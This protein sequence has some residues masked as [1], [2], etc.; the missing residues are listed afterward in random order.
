MAEKSSKEGLALVLIVGVVAVVSMVM[1][2]KGGA[3]GYVVYSGEMLRADGTIDELQGVIPS[4]NYGLNRAGGKQLSYFRDTSA[5]SVQDYSDA[6][7]KWCLDQGFSEAFCDCRYGL[8][9]SGS[10]C[11]RTLE[12]DHNTVAPVHEQPW[13]V[14][15]ATD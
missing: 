13:Y 5:G 1:M 3:S 8:G 15:S 2:A 6:N 14:G 9:G 12:V 10:E 4:D 11:T 7:Y